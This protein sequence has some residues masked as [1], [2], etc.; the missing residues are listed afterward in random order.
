MSTDF[1][2]LDL[3]KTDSSDTKDGIKQTNTDGVEQTHTDGIKQTHTNGVKHKTE[4]PSPTHKKVPNAAQ[5]NKTVAS[6]DAQC[7][8]AS[9]INITTSA[10]NVTSFN[11]QKEL[12]RTN[13]KT[14]SS[15]SETSDTSSSSD[16]ESR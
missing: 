11:A 1:E 7:A 3:S 16:D 10:K 13:K 12:Y 4:I 6:F 9:A 2:K 15:D 5:K 14:E 8:K